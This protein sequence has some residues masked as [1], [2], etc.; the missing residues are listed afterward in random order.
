MTREE[1]EEIV[2]KERPGLRIDADSFPDLDYLLSLYRVGKPERH[3][4]DLRELS[5]DDLRHH[6]ANL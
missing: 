6:I 1:A 4:L 2:V 5:A 3:N